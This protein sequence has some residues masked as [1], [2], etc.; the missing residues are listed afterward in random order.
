MEEFSLSHP[1]I[2]LKIRLGEIDRLRL[3]EETIPELTSWFTEKIK[4]DGCFKHPIIVDA[5][6][7]VVLDGMHRV[8]A[9]RNLG[10]RFIPICTLDY[11]N[12]NVL[13]GCWYR[14][15]NHQSDL[16]KI[17]GWIEDLGFTVEDSSR[18]AAAKLVAERKAIAAI[19]SRLECF[20]IHGTQRGIK[21]IYDAIKQIELK[22][23]SKGHSIGYGAEKNALKMVSSGKVFAALVVPMVAKEEVVA[24]GLSGDVFNHKTTRHVIPARPL[25]IDV[26]LE[27]LRGPNLEEANKILV[28]RLSKKRVELLPPGQVLDRFYEE[29]LYV[30]K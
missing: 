6:T 23:K 3:H 12:P 29:E 2:D 4:S 17:L 15:V 24:A 1:L 20:A 14:T 21:E 26:P 30:F 13:V 11:R 27:F 25:F 7:F 10:Y 19:V 22:L 9:S 16:E 28:D 18:D 8:T 5:N